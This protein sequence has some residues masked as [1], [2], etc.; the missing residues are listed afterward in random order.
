MILFNLSKKTDVFQWLHFIAVGAPGCG[1]TM[2]IQKF[3]AINPVLTLEE[4]QSVT[5]I[6]SLAGLIKPSE[7]LV[8]IPP[9]RIPHQTASI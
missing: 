5:R 9:F 2:G 4:A 1:K 6:W 7:P 3:P 8:R